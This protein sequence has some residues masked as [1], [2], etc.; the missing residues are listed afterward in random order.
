MRGKEEEEEE[1]RPRKKKGSLSVSE[2]AGGRRGAQGAKI[3]KSL[4]PQTERERGEE[5]TADKSV[6]RIVFLSPMT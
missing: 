5:V 6:F 2:R 1:G 4:P 3:G